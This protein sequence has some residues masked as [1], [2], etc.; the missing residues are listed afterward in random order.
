MSAARPGAVPRAAVLAGLAAIV[1]GFVGAGL[2][3]EVLRHPH[4]DHDMV[5]VAPADPLASDPRVPIDCPDPLPRE[6]MGRVGS[7]VGA[8]PQRVTSDDLTD[9]P[10]HWD[11]RA[12]IYRGEVV[13][14]LLRRGDVTWSQLNDDLYGGA[15]GPLPGHRDYRGANSGVGV[16]LPASAAEEVA[17]V[18]GPGIAGDVLEVRGTFRRVDPATGEM[19]VIRATSARL[20]QGGAPLET[21]PLTHRRVVAYLVVALALALVVTERIVAR[22][23]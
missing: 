16:E 13:G 6:G 15:L 14:A 2:L 5:V 9:C 1:L 8:L 12:V 3:A 10:D 17:L 18:G 21:P 23:R 11:G 19:A 20:V 4:P 22:V 7:L